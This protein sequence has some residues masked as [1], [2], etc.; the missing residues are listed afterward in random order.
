MF[1]IKKKLYVFEDFEEN[2]PFR[3]ILRN[4]HDFKTTCI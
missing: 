2:P 1:I 3:Y 4:R